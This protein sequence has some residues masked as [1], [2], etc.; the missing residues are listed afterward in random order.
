MVAPEPLRISPSKCLGTRRVLG[1]CAAVFAASL[2]IA[3]ATAT[4][5]VAAT[6]TYAMTDLGSLGYGVSYA[7]GINASAQ[8]A[9]RSYLTQTAPVSGCPPRHTCV[10][11]LAHAFSWSAGTMTDLGSLGGIYSEG[12]AINSAGDVAG[13]SNLSSSTYHAFLVHNGHM[14]DLGTLVPGGFSE[15]YGL[16]NFDEVVGYGSGA[17]GQHAFLDTGGK[18]SALPDLSSYGGGYSSASGINNLHQA[19]GSSDNAS[20]SSHAVLWSNGTVTD[21]GTL[22]GSQSAAYAIN[23]AGQVVG[24]AHTQSEATHAFLDTGGKM[25]DLGAYNI[26]TVG[27]AINSA[28][29][30]VGQTYGVDRSGNPFYHAFIYSGGAF[31][32]LNNLIPAGSGWELTD[33]TAINDKGQIAANGYSATTGKTHAFLLNPM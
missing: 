5:A 17:S 26:D 16:N 4:P 23:D 12:R 25:T 19:V 10:A 20:G 14:S 21:L 7:F 32:D 24:W 8:I 6:T 1:A 3:P 13:Y 15:A 9:G 11:H 33:A 28:G 31:Q 22:G 27:E 2:A 29:V 30:L 18:M